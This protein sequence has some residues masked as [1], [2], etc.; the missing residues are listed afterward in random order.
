MG[1]KK[2]NTSEYES[3]KIKRSIVD[4]VRANKEMTGVPVSVYFEKAADEKLL[5]DLNAIM[6]KSN[7]HAAM[8]EL[9]MKESNKKKK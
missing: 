9:L 6:V 4:R 2:D 7:Y 8:G 5:Y 1:R 3:V